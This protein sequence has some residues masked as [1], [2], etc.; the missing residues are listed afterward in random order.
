V[1]SDV[2]VGALGA[3]IEARP[4]D[5]RE[6]K[7]ELRHDN[8]AAV[9]QLARLLVCKQ[10]AVGATMRGVTG[11][12]ALSL[13]CGMFK[14]EGPTG[15]HMTFG[16]GGITEGTEARTAARGMGVMAVGAGH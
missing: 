6:T 14:H 2:A 9:A 4:A 8:V 5:R 16:A 3:F 7:V 11:N 1:N 13:R 12:A 10:V 15:I